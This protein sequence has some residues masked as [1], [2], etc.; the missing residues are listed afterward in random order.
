MP[1]SVISFSV[2]ISDPSAY[3][4]LPTVGT[5]YDVA[6]NG[7]GYMIKVDQPGSGNY[8]YQRG[9]QDLDPP[10]LATSDTPFSQAIDR[11]SMIAHSNFNGGAGQR[12]LDRPESDPSM[13]YDSY[14]VDVFS[15]SYRIK[16]LNT[17]PAAASGAGTNQKCV[18]AGDK[19]F[20]LSSGSGIAVLNDPDAISTSS[21]SVTKINNSGILDLVSDGT[22]WYACDGTTTGITR[23]T[24]TTEDA[25]LWSS[26]K[27]EK[28]A[29]A[30]NRLCVA[31]RGSGSSTPNTF[32]TLNQSGS[33]EV[34]SGR[35][36]LNKGWTI[37]SITGG[38]GFVWFSATNGD[39]SAVY[40]WHVS[41]DTPAVATEQIPGVVSCVYYYA[42]QV[43]VR[44]KEYLASGQ[45]RGV[46]YRCAVGSDGILVPYKT[47]VLDTPTTTDHGP[48]TFFGDDRFVYFSWQDMDDG[49]TI[50]GLGIIDLS[51]GGYARHFASSGGGASPTTV[52]AILKWRGRICF[53]LNGG[54]FYS[55]KTA[56]YVTS[57]YVKTS[58]SDLASLLNKVIDDVTITTL[59]LGSS[60]SIG[61]DLTYDG[62]QSYTSPSGWAM[63]TANQT[64]STLSINK[65]AR[66]VGVKVTLNGPGT[67]TP[68]VLVTQVRVHQLQLSDRIVRLVIDCGDRISDMKGNPLPENA[69][70]AG[71]LRARTLEALTQSRVKFQDID[72]AV[73]RTS[74]IYEVTNVTTN[75]GAHI[76][77]N[78]LGRKVTSPSCLVTLRKVS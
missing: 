51:T 50:D 15:D 67:S 14:G 78:T 73:T 8:G 76:Y 32:S 64:T 77:D 48:G 1:E 63:S 13:F 36:I 42:G 40:R 2:D 61:L 35:L 3:T 43:M 31:Y 19:V 23:G 52:E 53:T 74:E 22:Y 9:T 54:G 57:G 16:L 11:Y 39:K 55:Q 65:R 7:I 25:V 49:G 69:P 10:R 27:A 37:N 34:A 28:M 44:T 5:V 59:P 62:G 45:S 4:D 56:N 41:S 68:S 24:G 6:I 70:G 71:A 46:I 33:E 58:S 21:I 72:W 17:T 66:S 12:Y 38:N 29:W 18:L 60:Q 75:I 20:W 30:G 47:I 26:I